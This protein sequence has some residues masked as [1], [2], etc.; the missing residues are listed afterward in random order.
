MRRSIFKRL[1]QF[2]LVAALFAAVIG[3]SEYNPTGNDAAI[4]NNGQTSG[5]L[6]SFDNRINNDSRSDYSFSFTGEIDSFDE[7]K[8]V[9]FFKDQN[10]TT[11]VEKEAQIV[12]LPDGLKSPFDFS[13]LKTLNKVTVYGYTDKY[14]TAYIDLLEF[15]KETSSVISSSNG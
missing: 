7:V 4:V 3:C 10:F 5:I 9:I 14:G 11:F 1:G 6:G 8:R 13:M 2:V 15:Y 12:Q